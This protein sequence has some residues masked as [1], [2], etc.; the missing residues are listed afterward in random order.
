MLVVWCVAL[1]VTF[2]VVLFIDWLIHVFAVSNSCSIYGW[3]GFK[4]FYR[5]FKKYDWDDKEW[6]GYL[7]DRKNG[8]RY[9]A[10]IIEFNNIGMIM[11]TPWDWV[12][13]RI[14]V[15]RYLRSIKPPRYNWSGKEE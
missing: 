5:E 2:I 13:V 9:F 7:F 10:G 12:L 11:R 8:S 6:R 14:F 3:A 15:W 4:D 1:I